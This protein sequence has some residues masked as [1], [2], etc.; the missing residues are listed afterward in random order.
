MD[1]SIKNR[2][3]V[4]FI[5]SF[6]TIST[7]QTTQETTTGEDECFQ[8][9]DLA[10]VI[11]GSNSVG[12]Y[13]FQIVKDT[14]SRAVDA[15][16]FGENKTRCA[17]VLYS[18]QVTN[19]ITLTGDETEFKTNISTFV[20][21]DEATFTNF[22]IDYATKLLTDDKRDGVPLVIMLI[23]DGVTSDL[24]ATLSSAMISRSKGISTWGVGVGD[25]VNM[26]ELS[27]IATNGSNQVFKIGSFLEFQDRLLNLTRVVCNEAVVLPTFTI[28]ITTPVPSTDFTYT[29]NASLLVTTVTPRTGNDSDY[30]TELCKNSPSI[31]GVGY[32]HFPGDCTKVLQC[33]YNP[34]TGKTLVVI[35]Q[36][37]SGQFWDRSCLKCVDSWKADCPYDNCKVDTCS[38]GCIGVESYPMNGVCGGFWS[39]EKGKS[40]PKCCPPCYSY[41]AGYGCKF[42]NTCYDKCGTE[43][44]CADGIGV[45][46]KIP[47][48]YNATNYG[49]LTDTLGLYSTTCSH[50]E[51]SI[52][53]CKCEVKLLDTFMQDGQEC[54]PYHE[55]NSL[56][57]CSGAPVSFPIKQ[58][59][60]IGTLAL[61]IR[62]NLP[63]PHF[64]IT[65]TP[66]ASPSDNPTQLKIW[67]DDEGTHAAIGDPS[68]GG[69]VAT[70]LF[71]N[72]TGNLE[73]VVILRQ[74]LLTLGVTQDKFQYVS[75]VTAK[76]K[77]L[78]TD[79]Y[80][81][82]SV[83][84]DKSR[85]LINK[86]EFY[87]CKPDV[88]NIYLQN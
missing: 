80:H 7:Q 75:T 79:C 43:Q 57:E 78:C 38:G 16:Q 88:T 65:S 62:I 72:V 45:C 25:L 13:Y 81:N 63:A 24:K 74:G 73:I 22:G 77:K 10:F 64:V 84:G 15:L 56:L 30:Y 8:T 61:K 86:V 36:C 2:L 51:L 14:I 85:C 23:T 66:S 39:C 19:V 47:E 12:S 46:D 20:Y 32:V 6:V 44:E 35:R 40:Y 55:S 34:N 1:I 4:A 69:A 33:Y 5:I 76:S 59:T 29:S 82:F 27:S 17:A 53:E 52:V 21:P 37:P 87:N 11:D 58:K 28:P 26:D 50:S 9:L 41:M 83:T 3:I 60:D 54:R 49:V 48:W 42:S 71:K 31:A 67:A 18:T 68:K 70:V